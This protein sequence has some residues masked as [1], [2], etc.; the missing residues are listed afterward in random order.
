M[1]EIFHHDDPLLPKQVIKDQHVIKKI[2][3]EQYIQI[4]ILVDIH[5][6][7]HTWLNRV[8][9]K[10]KRTNESL[11]ISSRNRVKENPSGPRC[12]ASIG[13]PIMIYI[14]GNTFHPPGGNGCFML[15]INAASPC[16]QNK[17]TCCRN[18]AQAGQHNHQYSTVQHHLFWIIADKIIPDRQRLRFHLLPF[19]QN[20]QTLLWLV[21]HT[22][23]QVH[24]S[25]DQNPHRA[26][27]G[28][29]LILNF[30]IT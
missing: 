12:T 1:D 27:S 28:W 19:S 11:P 8:G 13:K 5:Y 21:T 29:F 16:P 25:I 30:I 4:P 26:T 24:V 20:Q 6:S 23:Q 22:H 2:N 14:S 15:Q 17:I 18:Q 9:T 10:M 7:E 3:A